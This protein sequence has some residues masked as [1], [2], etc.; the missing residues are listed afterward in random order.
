MVI[1]LFLLAYNASLVTAWPMNVSFLLHRHALNQYA[2]QFV[3]HP[4]KVHNGPMRIGL[5]PDNGAGQNR[6]A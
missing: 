4:S 5:L 1:T 6:N 2:Q 3:Q